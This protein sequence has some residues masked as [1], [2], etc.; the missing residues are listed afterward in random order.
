MSNKNGYLREFGKF[1]LD[2]QKHVLWYGDKPVNLPLKE[3]ELLCVLTENGGEVITKDELL[4]RVWPES[5]V[6]ESNLSRHVYLLRR[7][8]ANC[9]AENFIETV[10]RRGYRFTGEVRK[11]NNGNGHSLDDRQPEV[12]LLR[13]EAPEGSNETE[14][15]PFRR[16]TR[17][18]FTVSLTAVLAVGIMVFFGAWYDQTNTT[19]HATGIRSI[20]VLPFN[21]IGSSGENEDRGLGFADVLITRLSNMRE[22]RVRPTNAVSGF[23]HQDPIDF[24]KQL[25]VDAVLEGAIHRSGDKIRVTARLVKTGDSTVVWTGEFEKLS[26][27]EFRLQNEIALQIAGALALNIGVVEKRALAKNYTENADALQLYQRGRVEWS[28]RSW[29]GMI[30]AEQ[31]FR[32]AVE[33]DPNFALAYVGLADTQVFSSI[34][35]AESA[36][37][38]ALELDPNLAEAHATLGFIQMF[39]RWSWREAEGEFNRS[40]E[41]NPNYATAHHWYAQ[42]LAVQGRNAEA[43]AAMRRALDINPQSHNF[44]ADLGQIYYFNREYREAEEYCR[45]A[46]AIYPD[47][48]FAH[49]YLADIYSQTGEY[50]KAFEEEISAQKTNSTFANESA[51]RREELEANIAKQ[52]TIYREGG[53]RKF[54]ENLIGGPPEGAY[55][56][57]NAARY[58]FLGDK[59]KAL[60]LL[61]KAVEGKAFL[62]AFVKADPVFDPLRGEPRYQEILH[63]MNLAD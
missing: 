48:V 61:E 17:P 44:L 18:V 14:M 5:F 11:A 8:F 43:K 7:T 60:G 19:R 12:S 27:D 34:N 31:L 6:E 62:A 50:E 3:V 23:D 10:P 28:K 42:L 2:A 52:R 56:Y 35:E 9:G 13:Q 38:K 33:K 40:L 55:H 59:E 15:E 41:L 45:Q 21:T 54:V 53:H 63:R 37:Q 49:E 29:Q 20:A 30:D 4:N 36:V 58:A 16:I 25:D 39:L 22:I 32:R 57:L 46:L 47:F 24:G 26:G 1:R 51:K